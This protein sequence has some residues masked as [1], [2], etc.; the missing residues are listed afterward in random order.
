MPRPEKVDK[1][2]EIARLLR[3]AGFVVLTQFS[4]LSVSEM[5]ELRRRLKEAGAEYRVVKNTLTRIAAEQVG[6]AELV[7]FLQGPTAIAFGF[8]DEVS[9][10]RSLVEYERGARGTLK[11]VAGLM[12]GRLLTPAEVSIL[13]SLPSRS[14]LLARVI[15]G[16]QS[17]LYRLAWAFHSLLAGV[18]W[19]LDARRRQL[20]GGG[21]PGQLGT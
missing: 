8:G 15:G 3:S 17:P 16:M 12:D 10:A 20:E 4:G 21:E 14:E 11:V 6:K 7:Q 1:V 19:A 18:V 2:N 9:L 5:N 13:A